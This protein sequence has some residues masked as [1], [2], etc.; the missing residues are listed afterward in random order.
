MNYLR[1]MMTSLIKVIRYENLSKILKKNMVFKSDRESTSDKEMTDLSS[2]G[3]TTA[4]RQ[5]LVT[6]KAWFKISEIF[7]MS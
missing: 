4:C 5:I 2:D 3:E 1:S 6:V 7:Q